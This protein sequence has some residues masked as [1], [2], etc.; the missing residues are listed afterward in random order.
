MDMIR[1]TDP[2]RRNRGFNRTELLVALAVAIV[3]LVLLA[4]ALMRH[5]IEALRFQCVSNLKQIVVVEF[6][7]RHDREKESYHWG[8]P[9]AEGGTLDHPQA[10]HAWFQWSL[11]SNNLGSPK[12]LVCPADRSARVA[13]DWT[14]SPTG[15]FLN[16]T[17]QDAAL[18]YFINTSADLDHGLIPMNIEHAALAVVAGDR[19]VRVDG[20]SQ[21]CSRHTNLSYV[22]VSPLRLCRWVP[23]LHGPRGVVAMADGSVFSTD[24]VGLNHF[25]TNA[26]YAKDRPSAHLL[27]PE[28]PALK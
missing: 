14:M 21:A 16:P 13:S 6:T 11:I 5:R 27:V 28:R 26:S 2:P 9:S 25:L 18:S 10:H 8:T 4:P 12:V 24:H 3:L 23:P 20:P 17:F 15:G 19:T 7:W 22:C 1:R